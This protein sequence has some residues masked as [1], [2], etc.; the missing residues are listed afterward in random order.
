MAEEENEKEAIEKELKKIS[1]M[2][3]LKFSEG[4]FKK[5][6]EEAKNILKLFDEIEKVELSEEKSL[7]LHSREAGLREDEEKKFEWNPFENSKKELIKENK[8]LGP[9]IV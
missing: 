2:V 6:S 7:F 4:E 8:F 9:R 1:S 3:M 5:L